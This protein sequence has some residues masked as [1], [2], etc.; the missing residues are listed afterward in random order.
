VKPHARF[1][2]ELSFILSRGT[3]A[4]RLLRRLGEAPPTPLLREVYAELCDCL[5]E[6]RLF[7]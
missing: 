1:E 3:L 5:D 4:S 6:G 7:S 2:D